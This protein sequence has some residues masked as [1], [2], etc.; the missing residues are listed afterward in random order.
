[1]FDLEKR[2]RRFFELI[3]K[4]KLNNELTGDYKGDDLQSLFDKLLL[5]LRGFDLDLETCVEFVDLILFDTENGAKSTIWRLQQ[6]YE[7]Y[8]DFML[9]SFMKLGLEP[10][11]KLLKQ[12]VQF[13]LD[14]GFTVDQLVTS[15]WFHYRKWNSV[16]GL[17][18]I[19]LQSN[20][21]WYTMLK[22]V[23]NTRYLV[24]LSFV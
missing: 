10:N 13:D 11:D 8:S 24:M 17:Q 16:E 7:G 19:I 3:E 21:T 22:A 12:L 20:K 23:I 18:K 4:V 2:E 14:N 9:G 5:E 15:G 6:K 1:M